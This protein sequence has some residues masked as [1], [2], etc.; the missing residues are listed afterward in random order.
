MKSLMGIIYGIGSYLIF[1]VAF[2]YAVGFSGHFLVP[3]DINTGEVISWLPA[4]GINVLLLSLFALQHSIMARPAF[5][6][7]FTRIIPE[8][9]ERSTYVLL[10]SLI[11]LLIY[12]Q[13]KPLPEVVWSVENPIGA[14]IIQALFWLG[15]ATVFVSSFLINHFHLFGLKQVFDKWKGVADQEPVF[16]TRFL[17]NIVRHPIMLGFMVAFWATPV[18]T[19]GHLLFSVVT[20][21]YIVVAVKYLEEKDLEKAIGEQYVEYKK[22]VPMLIPFTGGE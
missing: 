6:E 15:W 20:T 7:W 16:A 11:L 12:W 9:I 14:G 5:K 10:S 3:K 21:A 8:S 17:Y 22:R 2:L 4:V 18:M 19:V 13:W 1:F